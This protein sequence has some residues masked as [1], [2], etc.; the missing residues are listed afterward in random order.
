VRERKQASKIEERFFHYVLFFPPTV[1]VLAVEANV[2]CAELPAA[3]IDPSK[4]R[5]VRS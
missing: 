1:L 4:M 3:H 5:L 2:R